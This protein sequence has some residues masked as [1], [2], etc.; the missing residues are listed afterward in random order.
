MNKV[1]KL[2]ITICI[3]YFF[4]WKF[5]V[6]LIL[7][8]AKI[9]DKKYIYIDLLIP[10]LI[11]FISANRWKLFLKQLGIEESIWSLIKI[12]SIS[13][14]QGLVLPSSQGYDV[15]RIYKIEKRHPKNRGGAGSTIIIERVI[16][17]IVLCSL[18][19]VFSIISKDFT[20]QNQVVLII[21]LITFALSIIIFL[22]LNKNLHRYFSNK[23]F[24]NK[25]LQ[26]G[27]DY[28]D[29]IY[30]AIAYFPYHKVLLSSI[31]LILM[32][33]LAT[34]V[35]VYLIFN[36]FGFDIP[37]YQ[38]ISLYPIISILSM[39]PITIS[40][41]GIREGFFVYFYSQLGVSADVAIGVSL[42][43]YMIIVLTPALI[44]SL[45]YLGD[46]FKKERTI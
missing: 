16:G 26:K 44:G 21:G 2:G 45:F 19:L 36:A 4:I 25:Y 3:L 27:F 12:N 39:I 40:G 29:K 14:F 6:N 18:S 43:N 24:Q 28:F 13:I 22:L 1:L 11:Q 41:F 37:L 23:S 17:L 34:I 46:I 7:L 15:L 38:H 10:I 32:F 30:K 42:V 8:F 35:S 20:N 33:Q 31:V 5:D 9:T